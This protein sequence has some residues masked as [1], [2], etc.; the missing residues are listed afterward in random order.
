MPTSTI[1]LPIREILK[2]IAS[3]AKT[4]FNASSTVDFK[5]EDYAPFML[6][7]YVAAEH[8]W[9]Q[10]TPELQLTAEELISRTLTMCASLAESVRTSALA[11]PEDVRDVKVAAKSMRAALKLRSYHYAEADVIHDEGNVLGLRPASQSEGHGLS[12]ED[13]AAKFADCV[14]TLGAVLRLIEASN[15][16]LPLSAVS[17]SLPPAK[18]RAGTAFIMMWMDPKHPELTDVADAVRTVFRSFEIRAVRADDIEHEG[19]ITDRVLNEI[20]TAEFLFAD[21]SGMR[22]NVYYE[23]GYAHALGKRVILFRKAGTGVHFDLAG[24]NCPEYE[25]LR[26]LKEKLSRRLVSITNRNP[27]GDKDI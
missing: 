17:A 9:G 4:F 20:R 2:Q 23:V 16:D 10:L 24:Y 19:L 6:S 15:Q 7:V 18:Y 12:P 26:D 14:Q 5:P 1:Q 21:L 27:L 13:A 11:G 8:Y 22:P 3:D 25:N